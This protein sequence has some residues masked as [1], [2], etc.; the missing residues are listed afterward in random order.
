MTGESDEGRMHAKRRRVGV[1][2]TAAERGGGEG[3]RSSCVA[4]SCLSWR[5]RGTAGRIFAGTSENSLRRRRP[6][7]ERRTE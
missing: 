4:S 2:A 7:G 6:R 5:W 3:K 1:D